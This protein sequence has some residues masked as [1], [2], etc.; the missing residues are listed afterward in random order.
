MGDFDRANGAREVGLG[1]HGF[2]GRSELDASQV[3]F[4]RWENSDAL[5]LGEGSLDL[6]FGEGSLSSDNEG[7]RGGSLGD[8]SPDVGVQVGGTKLFSDSFQG[9]ASGAARSF[10]RREDN[11]NVFFPCKDFSGLLAFL[12]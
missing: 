1:E 11:R 6:L 9:I 8:G 7:V 5:R 4:V 12:D 10:I 3:P 2:F